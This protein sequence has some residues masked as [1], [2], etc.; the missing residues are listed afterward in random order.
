MEVLLMRE[1]K[2]LTYYVDFELLRIINVTVK[3]S[4]RER[5]LPHDMHQ[6]LVIELESPIL[7]SILRQKIGE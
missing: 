1:W 7:G 3:H 4:L 5:I 6:K 2:R